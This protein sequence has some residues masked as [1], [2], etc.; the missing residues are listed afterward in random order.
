[1]PKSGIKKP[2]L[3]DDIVVLPNGDFARWND[4]T[5]TEPRVQP[6]AELPPS[7]EYEDLVRFFSPKPEPPYPGTLAAEW[8][9]EGRCQ[10]CGELGRIHM[11]TM[12]CSIH[13]PYT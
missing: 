5:P 13:G 12:I 9:A 2:N 4:W 1:M 10:Q 11:S 8:K 6:Q 7:P 3:G